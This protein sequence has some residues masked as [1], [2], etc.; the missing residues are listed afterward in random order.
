MKL[1]PASDEDDH[2][3][4]ITRLLKD[5]RASEPDYPA[6]LLAARREV[7]LAQVERLQPAAVREE[8]AEGDQEI[9]RLL[10]KLKVAESNGY[11]VYLFTARRSAFVR[12]IRAAAETSLLDQFRA[13]LE[14]I[15]QPQAK[16]P[17]VRRLSLAIA[18]LVAAALLGS[19]LLGHTGP[20]VQPAPSQV[21]VVPTQAGAGA[22]ALTICPPAGRSPGC[23]AGD[24]AQDLANT[25]NGPARPA[26]S[27]D[28]RPGQG[29]AH[30]ASYVNDGR[31]GA[32]WVS[33]G[34]DSWIKIDLGRV[35][36][37]NTVTIQKGYT[38]SSDQGDP[39]Q[40]V[41][42]VAVEDSYEDGNSDNDAV[43]YA[44]V[45]DSAEAGFR[46]AVSHTEAIQTYF[47]ATRAR[48]VKITFEK[49]G[50]AIDE[51]G[52]F[53][54]TPVAATEQP[55]STTMSTATSA[56]VLTDTLTSVTTDAASSTPTATPTSLPTN[57]RP[58]IE[59]SV[60]V[61]A[62]PLPSQTPIPVLTIVP[63]TIVPPTIFTPTILPP[64]ITAP[65]V[66]PS[67]VST[68]PIVVTGNGQTLTFVCNGNAAE[69]R[70]H[71]NTITLLGSCSSITVT[72]NGNLVLW[73]SGLPVI[74]N[75]GNDNI[76]R[77][78]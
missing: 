30:L 48:Y 23:P 74:I 57:T 63:P 72:G 43:E 21:A 40:F 18:T 26:V 29:E 53:L 37:L 76:V 34:P 2:D 46:G 44:Q 62:T 38:A 28:A 77:Q 1:P 56:A 6:R 9:I 68:E 22:V 50:A 3:P 17:D 10:R 65:T 12:Q 52:V 42:A 25:T 15:F 8:L 35:T 11:P 47:P 54:V 16:N 31:G 61:P 49:A 67:P 66:P 20:G 14:R 69:I 78:E 51:I 45:F 59:P 70:G 36:T 5:L 32:S 60:P 73:Q 7:F 41:I 55:V 27:K 39:G 58:P 64:T 71:A 33:D 4:R 13:T 24:P 19:L 75:N